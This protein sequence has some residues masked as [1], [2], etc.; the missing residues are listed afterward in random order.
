MLFLME[1][2]QGFVA[3]EDVSW[4]FSLA[5]PPKKSLTWKESISI[6]AEPIAERDDANASQY[7]SR[8]GE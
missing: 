5:G 8:A 1:A 4:G 7:H 3:C 2:G 6:E